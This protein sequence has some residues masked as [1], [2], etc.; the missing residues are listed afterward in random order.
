MDGRGSKPGERRG[1]RKKGTPNKANAEI[2]AAAQAFGADAIK[3][4][5]E[6]AGLINGG[7]GKAQSEQA[8]VSAVTQLLDRGYGRP[9][10]VVEGS[11]DGPPVK[12]LIEIAWLGTASNA[13]KS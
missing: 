12:T 9:A 8:Q 13:S 11:D 10:T 1:G 2:K 7:Q 4:L 6:L 5:A 3:K